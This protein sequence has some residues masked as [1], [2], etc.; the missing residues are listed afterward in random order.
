MYANGEG[1]RQDKA[2]AWANLA[3]VDGSADAVTLRDGTAQRLS[4]AQLAEAQK[5]SSELEARIQNTR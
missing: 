3:S 5:L 2:Y 4:P 1:V